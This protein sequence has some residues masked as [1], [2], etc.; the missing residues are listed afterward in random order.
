MYLNPQI[1]TFNLHWYAVCVQLFSSG[2]CQGGEDEQGILGFLEQDI[3][4]E[5]NRGKRLV[6]ICTS[7]PCFQPQDLALILF[8]MHK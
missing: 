2:L 8:L 7:Q 6:C 3:K 5:V 1:F 4:Q